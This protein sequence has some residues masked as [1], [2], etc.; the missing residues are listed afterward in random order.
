M[1]ESASRKTD[2][3]KRI[4][5]TILKTKAGTA[6]S[7]IAAQLKRVM[8]RYLYLGS[9]YECPFCNSRLRRFL[10]YGIPIPI[11]TEARIVGAGRRENGLCPVC[12][13]LDR[14]RLLWLYLKQKTDI[15]Q[16]RIKLLHIAPEGGLGR[17]FAGQLNLDWLTADI[18]GVGVMVQMDITDIHYPDASFDAVICCHVIQDV[19]DDH[20]AMSELYRVLRPG[21]WGI[22]Q[23]P[24]ALLLNKSFEGLSTGGDDERLRLFGHKEHVRV[25]SGSDYKDRLERAGFDVN[26]FRWTEER[27]SFG[28][29]E[30]KFALIEDEPLFH[31]SKPMNEFSKTCES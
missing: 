3:K 20:K 23:V 13:T 5:N 12:S 17:I 16:K 18:S 27:E 6:F 26:V 25:Y 21:G 15:L 28:G 14:E 10:P 11:I 8:N 9:S 7:S 30:N 4:A 24:I 29:K 31:V 1:P 19:I 22:L 2:L